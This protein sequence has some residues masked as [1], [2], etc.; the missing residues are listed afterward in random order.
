MHYF[1]RHTRLY[2]KLLFL[3]LRS[4]LE[5]NLDFLIGALSSLL[6]QA[7]SLI[8]IWAVFSR[9]PKVQGWT[10]WEVAF[11][12]GMATIPRG[13]AEVFMNGSWAM[14]R[15]VSS[16]DFD[17][18]LLRPVPIILQIVTQR[19][20]VTGLTDI[21]VGASV[22]GVSASHLGISWNL[23]DCVFLLVVLVCGMGIIG[24]VNI[25]TNS[26]AFWHPDDT[27]AFQVFVVRFMN[28]A[29][30]PV[31]IY[32]Q[33]LQIFLCWIVP[34]AFVGYFP[35]LVLLRKNIDH[36]WLGWFSPVVLIGVSLITSLIWRRGLRHYES[37]GH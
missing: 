34:Y 37:A 3:H 35:A 20:N 24:V 23:I 21:A 14:R 33:V 18:L 17:R 9:I 4:H 28:L 16:G 6:G 31:T 27:G 5:Y 12:Y 26:L 7:A 29:Q 19:F 2:V 10:I 30:Y 11:L 13:M 8:F 15:L 1:L 32:G 36:A 22:L 25:A